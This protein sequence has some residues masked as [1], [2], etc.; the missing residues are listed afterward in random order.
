MLHDSNTPVPLGRWYWLLA[1][2]TLRPPG[3][4][5][6]APPATDAT[7]IGTARSVTAVAAALLALHALLAWWVRAAGVM[8]INDD[9]AYILLA[10]ALRDFGYYEVFRVGMPGHT[11]YPPGYPTLLALWGTIFGESFDGFLLLGIAISTVALGLVF[12]TLRR[13]WSPIVALL[14]LLPLTLNPY[15]ITSAGQLA[16]EAPYVFF[17]MLALFLLAAA[18]PTR[19]M[20]VAGSAAAIA[21]ALTRGTGVMLLVA[22]GVHWLLSGR[23]RVALSFAVACAASAGAWLLWTWRAPEHYVG[24]SYLA[25]ATF[26]GSGR[27]RSPLAV[28]WERLAGAFPDY[29][30][31]LMPQSLPLPGFAG[32]LLDNALGALA[33]VVGLTVG[34]FV[35]GR[36]WRVAALYLLAYCALLFIWP[37]RLQRFVVP[38]L[39]LLVPVVILGV[40]ALAARLRPRLGT[41]AMLVMALVMTVVGCYRTAAV[42]RESAACQPGHP[43]PPAECL[44]PD[45]QSFFA[46]LSYI[47][48]HT[49][50]DAV[51]LVAK[52]TPLYYYT[53]RQ[54]ISFERA[55]GHRPDEFVE[56]LR[57][58]G[59]GYI[60]AGSV[61]HAELTML[62]RLLAAN[63]EQ[64]ELVAHFP[65]R[66]YLFAVP[67][68]DAATAGRDG[69]CAAVAEYRQ[70]NADRD[71]EHNF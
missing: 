13:L 31:V 62:T 8:T 46:A 24:V 1:A 41:P 10:R 63:C 37:W 49:P 68:A 69:A 19:P 29:L 45:Q 42:V 17:S 34:M 30:A 50:R 21:A 44:R 53:G 7:R 33:M 51:F 56:A 71:F 39:P 32:T 12:L 38:I 3:D 67:P 54:T 36:R 25:D 9:A 59:V 70:R 55:I 26:T 61:H 35:L 64:L 5:V 28:L 40:G 58:D 11:Q 23:W 2:V 47:G 6:A 60:L 16:S 15:L 14:C 43:V 57:S 52:P 65:H 66:T 20:L 48:E 4:A 18:R 27:S 22:L